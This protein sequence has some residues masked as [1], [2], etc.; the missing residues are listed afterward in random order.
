M[1]TFARA[2]AGSP[3]ADGAV[4]CAHCGLPVPAGLVAGDPGDAGPS[5]CCA[6]CRGVF[7][8]LRACG[9]DRYYE[10]LAAERERGA[11][12]D[13]RPAA[14][15]G[16][17]FE[18]LDRPEFLAAHARIAS[19]G[20]LAIEVRLDGLHCAAC[21]WLLEA[22]PRIEPG[23]LEIRIDLSRSTARVEWDPAR[24]GLSRV[25]RRL[26]RLGY[27][28]LPFADADAE[29]R[30][31]AIDRAWFA[32]IG[33]S[34]AIASNAM[35]VAFALYGGILA[36]MAPGY[37]LFFQ[38]IS[39]ALALVSLAGP[40][41]LFFRNA[42]VA[43]RTRTPH[44][45]IP[46]A[47]GLF[48][49]TASGLVNTALG[50]DGIYCESVTM[51]V[52]LLLAGRFVQY[53]QQ[54]KARQR[55]ELL[56]A[57]VPSVARRRDESGAV[58]E[59]PIEALAIGDLVE[60]PVGEIVPVDGVLRSAEGHLELAHL[61]GE[62]RPQRLARGEAVWA[63]AKAI[64]AAIT[65]ETRATG[66]AT[67][68]GRL[69]ALVREAALRRPHLVELADRMS[70]WF[71]LAVLAVAAFTFLFWWH[72]GF[73][74]ALSRTVA[75]LVVTCPCA[76]GLATPLGVVAGIGKAA[77]S[78]VLVKGGDV[79]ERLARPGTIVLDK[80]GT[81]TAGIVAVTGTRG[82]AA[83]EEVRDALRLAAA[84]ERT[85]VHPVAKAIVAA[86]AGPAGEIERQAE[87]PG[88]GMTG[89]VEGR[90]VTI[91]SPRFL[92]ARGRR[93]AGPEPG[94]RRPRRPLRR[95]GRGG[96]RDPPRRGR[97]RRRPPGRGLAARDGQRRRPSGR[98]PRRPRGRTRRR[99]DPR[100]THA[101][102]EARA[103]PRRRP[104]GPGGHGRRRRE[105]PRGPRRRRRRRRG[106]RRRPVGAARRRRVSCRG[107]RAAALAAR[108]RL[109]QHHA[110]DPHRARRVG[111]LQ[112]AR[113]GAGLRRP[114]EPA[115]RRRAHAG[116]RP[117]RH[118]ARPADAAV[119]SRSAR[120][121]FLME[122]IFII[123]PLAL[124]IAGL[125]VAAFLW[126]ARNDQF[127]DLET[128]AMRMLGEDREVAKGRSGPV[129]ADSRPP[130]GR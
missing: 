53:R 116:E 66:E 21:V 92:A 28:V 1:T 101:R 59:V 24:L 36:P 5:F 3:P 38:W 95:R 27:Q 88:G 94:L 111:R 123:L 127:A 89:R 81:L 106:A 26:D 72:L 42:L 98:P 102:G 11:D 76:L 32:R 16:R 20:R 69:V 124:I 39:V 43:L 8:S 121:D 99:R 41:R 10:L 119:R 108:P 112:P 47:F 56:T 45:D 118:R 105:R 90:E 84:L 50:H 128:P 9:L 79:L 77:R 110:G 125:S 130:R 57:L 34:A 31:A 52:F 86:F 80:T 114:R 109:G 82:L 2:V 15:T 58:E 83:A 44:M 122:L 97:H 35:A 65:V 7:E 103:G 25:A 113:R 71:L 29:R 117:D 46:V 62:S 70:G 17:G 73:A 49:A 104:R 85:S 74:A 40:G 126:A 54:R 23:L 107:R 18:H 96:R 55:V 22:L 93:P 60:V 64:G 14:I 115:R 120:R 13:A 12:R 48:A 61:T 6:G 100:R 51:L 129:N 91:G 67:R 75:M 30:D 37:R 4:A 68:A 78:G 63:G 33:V 87:T 19:D